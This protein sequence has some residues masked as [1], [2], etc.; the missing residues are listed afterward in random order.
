MKSRTLFLTLLLVL[1]CT[2][3]KPLEVQGPP[4]SP[5]VQAQIDAR[6]EQDEE[7]DPVVR[8]NRLHLQGNLDGALTEIKKALNA[9]PDDGRARYFYANFLLEKGELRGAA[10]EFQRA[11]DL[12]SK[13]V[14]IVICW[15][16]LGEVRERLGEHPAAL[17]AYL[18]AVQAEREIDQKIAADPKKSSSI[19]SAVPH[20]SPEPW[21]NLARIYLFLGELDKSLDALAQARQRAPRDAFTES[22]AV[23]AFQRL[24]DEDHAIECARRFLEI[25]GDDPIFT[26]RAS[27]LRELVRGKTPP[28]ALPERRALVDFVR[29][30]LRPKLPES[31]PDED[32]FHQNPN[33]RLLR[34]DDR[35]VFVTII[36]Q[37][38]SPRLRGRGRG[39]SLASAVA[40]AVATIKDS[41]TYNPVHTRGAAVRIDVERGELEP[42]ELSASDA[43][44]E[45][46]TDGE[47]HVV[48]ASLQAK[49]PV[50][51]GMHGIALRVDERELF[52]LPGDPVTEDLPDLKAMLEFA[53]KEGGLAANAWE[54]AT[55]RVFRFKTESFCS[56]APGVA[57]IELVRGEPLPF[58]EATP[59]ILLEAAGAGATWLAQDLVLEERPA[60]SAGNGPGAKRWLHE[61]LP[62]GEVA[63]V[64]TLTF[65]KFHYEYKARQDTFDENNYNE[66][67]HAGAGLALAETFLRTGHS[68]LRDAGELAARWLEDR[69][70]AEDQGRIAIVVNR[71]AKLGTQALALALEDA[72]VEAASDQDP[73]RAAFR[74]GLAR[75]LVQ[76]MR[77]DG[78]F[79]ASVPARGAVPPRSEDSQFFPGEAVFALVRHFKST[80]DRRWLEAATKGADARIQE[81]QRRAKEGSPML[82]AW[83]ARAICEMDELDGIESDAQAARRAFALEVAKQTVAHQMTDEKGDAAGGLAEPGELFPRGMPTASLGEGLAAVAG[84]A[85]RHGLPQAREL[86]D[87]ARKAAA[88]ALRHQYTARNSF[89]LPNAERARGAFRSVLTGSRVRIDGVQHNVEFLLLV[90]K[91]LRE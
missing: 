76:A 82:D 81:W 58:P 26:E 70:Q 84:M 8:A 10:T 35:A 25:A 71:S 68:E 57:P 65:A 80:G 56:P 20:G 77:E 46:Q 62:N 47:E 38:G 79:P 6:S 27:E 24:G 16:H 3:T 37:D 40:G 5:S 86:R 1:G 52:C 29:A 30:A 11:I 67:R 44:F 4:P 91:L 31:E 87:A 23:R 59:A 43:R 12:K 13:D 88:F 42:V 41:K 28:L 2:T 85:R 64:Q 49:P 48:V 78:T 19:N 55:S 33:A 89:Y 75:T 36:T 63:I 90:E 39:K 32:Y 45:Q 54:N 15:T 14:P 73:T 51:P 18:G 72:L 21:R 50:E 9:N 74:D 34:V 61:Q 69:A 7:K 60:T 22:L 83:L 17:E 53:S 66:V